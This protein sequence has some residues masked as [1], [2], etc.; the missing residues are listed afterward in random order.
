MSIEWV[1]AQI[2]SWV[3]SYVAVFCLLSMLVWSAIAYLYTN[4]WHQI[5]RDCTIYFVTTGI[6]TLFLTLS[7][8]QPDIYLWKPITWFSFSMLLVMELLWIA[9]MIESLLHTLHI[10]PEHLSQPTPTRDTLRSR[11]SYSRR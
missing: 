9:F 6:L 8:T 10:L 1:T 3:S 7:P 2:G 4:K 11:T 5:V